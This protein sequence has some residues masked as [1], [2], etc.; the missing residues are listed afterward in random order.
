MFC[1]TKMPREIDKI[2]EVTYS[3]QNETNIEKY[4]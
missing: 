4:T 2:W 3:A 1:F